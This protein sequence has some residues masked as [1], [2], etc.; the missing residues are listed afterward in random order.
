[1]SQLPELLGELEADAPLSKLTHERDVGEDED[2]QHG[3]LHLGR[4]S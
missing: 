3:G 4:P 1:V 2:P